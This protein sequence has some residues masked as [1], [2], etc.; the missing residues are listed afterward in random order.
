M[1]SLFDSGCGAFLYVPLEE[2]TGGV[3]VELWRSSGALLRRET[4]LPG[5][6]STGVSLGTVVPMVGTLKAVVVA[7]RGST[8]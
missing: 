1:A 3:L 2:P 6:A 5:L 4:S 8:A 7:L